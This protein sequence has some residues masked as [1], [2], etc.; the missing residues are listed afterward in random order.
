M[1]PL[2]LTFQRALY[3]QTTPTA[4]MNG[5]PTTFYVLP[6]WGYSGPTPCSTS[7]SWRLGRLF[8]IAL[9]VFGRLEGNFAEEL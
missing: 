6:T 4:I 9:S 7:V 8:V 3:A 1:V 5:K 2:V